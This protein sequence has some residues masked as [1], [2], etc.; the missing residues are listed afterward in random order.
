MSWGPGPQAFDLVWSWEGGEDEGG[1]D[2]GLGAHQE[3][4]GIMGAPVWTD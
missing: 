2:E 3:Q 1:E 4:E